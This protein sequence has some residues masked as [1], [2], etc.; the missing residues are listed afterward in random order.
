YEGIIPN[1]PE[2]TYS[3]IISAFVGDNYFVEDYEIIVAATS[4]VEEEN[5]IFP[6][7]FAI[8]II[9]ISSLAIYLYA[10]QTYLKFPKQV[11]KVR[12][13]RKTLR[14]KDA[15]SITIIG[16]ESALKSRYNENLGKDTSDL[17][18]KRSP[19]IAKPIEQKITPDKP[20]EQKMEPDQLTE[21]VIAKKE[22]LDDLVKD[23]PK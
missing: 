17:K 3:I 23:S 2:G 22:E 8:S 12:K 6:I 16:R 15:P 1:F 5:I 20:L 14:R 9:L 7:L 13:Y 19:G 11:R 4:L 21:K 10:Y 18:L